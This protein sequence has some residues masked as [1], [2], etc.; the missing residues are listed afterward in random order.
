MVHLISI[1]LN[2]KLI[3][4]HYFHRNKFIK[5]RKG[6]HQSIMHYKKIWYLRI[7]IFQLVH[8]RFHV[9]YSLKKSIT[10]YFWNGKILTLLSWHMLLSYL[11]KPMTM[12]LLKMKTKMIKPPNI[13]LSSTKKH[14]SIREVIFPL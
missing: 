8:Q 11:V 3:C 10:S 14:E 1:H 5:L 6:K 12:L 4:F 13:S 7:Y 9:V 2:Q